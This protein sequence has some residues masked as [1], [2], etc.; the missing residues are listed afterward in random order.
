MLQRLRD[1]IPVTHLSALL[2]IKGR[3]ANSNLRIDMRYRGTCIGGHM[4]K[5]LGESILVFTEESV[6]KDLFFPPR[7]QLRNW[8]FTPQKNVVRAIDRFLNNKNPWPWFPAFG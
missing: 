5:A 1:D 6:Y 8:F 2:E 4:A 7:L 3:V